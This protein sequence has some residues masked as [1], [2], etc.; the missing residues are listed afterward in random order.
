MQNTTSPSR[1]VRICVVAVPGALCTALAG[2]LDIFR[3]ADELVR[4]RHP[5]PRF[6]C[7]VAG[8]PG[9][10]IDTFGG[11]QLD[12][13]APSTR[14]RPDAVLLGAAGVHAAKIMASAER[15]AGTHAGVFRWF[16]RTAARGGVVATGCVGTAWF[17]AAGLLSGR[18]ATTS[19]FLRPALAAAYPQ[20]NFDA[21]STVV[22]DGPVV[23]AGAAMAYLDLAL[24]L[25]GRLGS[26][27]LRARTAQVLL[28]DNSRRSEALFAALSHLE[29]DNPFVRRVAERMR[30]HPEVG[31]VAGLARKEGV[32]LRTLQRR[33]RQATGMSPKEYWQ[34]VRVERARYLLETSNEPV[35]Q[36]ARTL[37]YADA[38]ALHRAFVGRLGVPP[39]A[40]R[41]RF[42]RRT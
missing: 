18:R 34:R 29:T 38:S 31:S 25:V 5:G 4:R 15:D 8:L 39:A 2:P 33:F 11:L 24:H 6:E 14:S 16:H 36:I 40:Y 19:A 37:G 9:G 21:S 12:L 26:P 35:A 3:T 10:R 28:L 22:S 7:R 1:P 42:R 13:P 41:T 32:T 23:T 20:V 30:L 17:A 27:A